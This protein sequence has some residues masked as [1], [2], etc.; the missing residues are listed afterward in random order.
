VIPLNI[1][2]ITQDNTG[3]EKESNK[4]IKPFINVLRLPS[5]H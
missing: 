4:K 2:F 1:I 5:G 3:N